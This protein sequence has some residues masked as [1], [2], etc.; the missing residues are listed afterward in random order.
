VEAVEVLSQDPELGV[1]LDAPQRAAARRRAIARVLHVPEGPWDVSTEGPGPPGHF[2]LLLLEGMLARD[3]ALGNRT[4]IELLGPGDLLR[5]WVRLGNHSSIHLEEG[6]VATEPASFAVLDPGFARAIAPWP[7]IGGALMDRLALRS[8]WIAFHL[9]VCHLRRV[10]TRLL[11]VLWYFGD[12][13]GRVTP[14]GVRLPVRLTHRLL[15]GVIGAERSSVS[16]AAQTLS[17]RQKVSRHAD[18]SWRLLGDPPGE[19]RT[20]HERS[21]GPTLASG[22]SAR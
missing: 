21:V 4:G 10:D 17:R 18:G 13:W 3:V 16:K 11:V 1:D 5:P 22:S 19:L 20:V 6:F 8:R 14:Q 7:A 9:A 12:R 15:A 2:G